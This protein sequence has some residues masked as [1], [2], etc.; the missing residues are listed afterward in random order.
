MGASRIV[1]RVASACAG[2]YPQRREPCKVSLPDAQTRPPARLRA[3]A[4]VHAVAATRKT[5]CQRTTILDGV[6][7]RAVNV[8]MRGCPALAGLLILLLLLLALPILRIGVEMVA[9]R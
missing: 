4:S 3:R 9:L 5:G 6:I 2:L 8:G 7:R 1:L